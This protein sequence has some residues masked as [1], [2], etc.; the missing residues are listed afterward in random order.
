MKSAFA[1]FDDTQMRQVTS[2]VTK[3]ISEQP[4]AEDVVINMPEQHTW[5]GDIIDWITG[6]M[7]SVQITFI[8]A[9]ALIIIVFLF[10]RSPVSDFIP[11]A[12][13]LT[14]KKKR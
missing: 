6:A 7:P 12:K 8:I 4:V 9:V 3:A 11:G 5:Y 2:T 1:G 10:L 14:K 13:H